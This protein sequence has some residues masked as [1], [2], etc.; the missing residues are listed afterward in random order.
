MSAPS[1][2]APQASATRWQ[3]A[4]VL[5]PL[6]AASALGTLMAPSWTTPFT[7]L[8]GPWAGHVLGHSD[9]TLATVAAEASWAASAAAAVAL[10]LFVAG[11]RRWSRWVW[12]LGA[13]GSTVWAS[14]AL[15]SVLNTLS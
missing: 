4:V 3:R 2:A 5:A 15:L 7:P 14:L 10:G 12:A 13:L 6:V 11:P 9:C 1:V 8:L